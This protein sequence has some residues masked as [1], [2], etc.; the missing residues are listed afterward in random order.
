MLVQHML[1]KRIKKARLTAGFGQAEL[2]RLI[3][4]QPITLWKIE[5]SRVD[6]GLKTLERI[7]TALR[8]TIDSLVHGTRSAPPSE[9]P[10]GEVS[11]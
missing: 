8:V 1:G 9:S 11:G 3:G 4:I 6:P 2:A 10:N 7:A 5:N